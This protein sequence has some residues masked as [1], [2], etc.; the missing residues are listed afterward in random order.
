MTEG[1]LSLETPVRSVL[2]ARVAILQ[3]L[4]QRLLSPLRESTHGA[5]LAICERHPRLHDRLLDV[6][7]AWTT[8][9]RP[10][11]VPAVSLL[12]ELVHEADASLT[13]EETMHLAEGL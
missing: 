8:T 13:R 5:A 7:E 2:A 11:R 4:R 3:A 10:N 9:H 6:L 12:Q 1:G